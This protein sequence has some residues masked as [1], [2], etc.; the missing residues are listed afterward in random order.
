MF[1]G[2][3][4]AEVRTTAELDIRGGMQPAADWGRNGKSQKTFQTI[5]YDHQ[6][7]PINSTELISLPVGFYIYDGLRQ[8]CNYI[9]PQNVYA[10][11]ACWAFWYLKVAII[12]LAIPLCPEALGYC[13]ERHHH[14][15]CL[16]SLE[17]GRKCEFLGSSAELGS[18]NW[19]HRF[20]PN[21]SAL[22][23]AK[24]WL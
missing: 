3:K 2:E 19:P 24:W 1:F 5:D 13:K 23:S 18:L 6:T 10:D 16:R 17:V 15:S 21:P 4:L 8:L 7:L 9:G 20:L 12:S 11:S 14:S 22:C